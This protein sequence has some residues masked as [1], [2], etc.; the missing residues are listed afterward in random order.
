MDSADSQ[1]RPSMLSAYWVVL[2]GSGLYVA[3]MFLPAFDAMFLDENLVGYE[4]A[5]ICLALPVETLLDDPRDFLQANIAPLAIAILVGGAVNMAV[6]SGFVAV[7]VRRW[8]VRWM[9]FGCL[10]FAALGA[11]AIP[12]LSRQDDSPDFEGTLYDEFHTGYFV[13]MVS[14]WLLAAGAFLCARQLK[15]TDGR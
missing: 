1:N 7:L 15:R 11:T 2:A 6:V 12:L 3:S 10:L 14:C 8:S 4:V 9:A 5:W 13:W